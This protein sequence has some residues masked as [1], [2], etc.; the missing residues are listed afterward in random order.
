MRR[1]DQEGRVNRLREV[2]EN[3]GKQLSGLPLVH[4]ML[5]VALAGVIV[6]VLLLV[7]SQSSRSAMVA[8]LPGAT[9]QE[10]ARAQ[11]HLTSIGIRTGADGSGRL[12]VQAEDR[13][14]A[15]ASLVETGQG[16]T[17]P[18]R[19]IGSLVEGTS[20][21]NS[22]SDNDRQY[23][24]NLQE[25]LSRV[26]GGFSGVEWAS[27]VMDVP[28]PVGLGQTFR[29]PTASVTVR[30]R[31]GAI[32]SQEQVD[33]IA[34]TVAG[35]RAGLSLLDV[36]VVDQ[37]AGR[38]L[39]ARRPDDYGATSYIEHQDKVERRV[40]EKLGMTLGYIR[41]VLIAVSAQV[42]VTRRVTSVR[43]ALPTGS[44]TV[45]IP[46]REQGD[47]QEITQAT[48]AAAPGLS[49]NLADD[50]ARS[51]SGGGG[52]RTSTEKTESEFVVS[53][54]TRSEDIVDP[55]GMP[56]RITAVVHLPREYIED[57]VRQGRAGA[58]AA[59]AAAGGGAAGGGVDAP[60]TQAEIEGAFATEKARLEAD[61]RPLL[62]T[63][64][65]E[66]GVESAEA[67][68][69]IVVSL[70]PVPS[71][72]S[73]GP[74]QEAGL[75]ALGGGGGGSGGGGVL[76]VS[77]GVLGLIQT[78]VLLAL[79]VGAIGTMLVVV[80]RAGKPLDLPTAESIVGLPP[81]LEA[82]ADVVG[83]ADET[84]TAM[85]GIELADGELEAK[86]KLESVTQMVKNNPRDAA[87]LL[88]RWLA[89]EH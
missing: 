7:W 88:N 47:T 12:T 66:A 30:M 5:F 17:D 49:S 1:A 61:L 71:L 2:M 43:S 38:A 79:A 39:R 65:V 46:R 52:S 22:R 42:D 4:R 9:A 13:V 63:A 67:E 41:G 37:T 3:I 48:P 8:L 34:A 31:R 70:I 16:P 14:R 89:V 62:R 77:G 25:G 78:G 20:W 23:Y 83:E 27:V 51:P 57:L 54:G 55:R 35:S 64:A 85:M 10:M 24:A 11:E 72:A 53:V 45:A 32:L 26:V 40:A 18:T 36:S 6:L 73:L 76:G 33:A 15:L 58:A 60:V 74:V 29:K 86:K 75:F 56:T 28:E 69:G 81:A 84:Q 50:I 21:M 68:Q 19:A 44:G 59:G 87:G 80:R 82:G